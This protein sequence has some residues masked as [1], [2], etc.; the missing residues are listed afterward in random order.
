M[1]SCPHFYLLFIDWKHIQIFFF[2]FLLSFFSK[3]IAGVVKCLENRSHNLETGDMIKFG[4]VVGME[5][6]NGTTHTVKGT[7]S[8]IL[9]EVHVAKQLIAKSVIWCHSD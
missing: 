2:W 4:E 1:S 3:A 7:V 6:V 9:D 5:A 8:I